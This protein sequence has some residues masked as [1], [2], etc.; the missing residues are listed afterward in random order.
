[1]DRPPAGV[2]GVLWYLARIQS[3]FFDATP[4]A[5]LNKTLALS[6][7]GRDERSTTKVH[8]GTFGILPVGTI[9]LW[10]VV[11]SKTDVDFV[12]H[13]GVAMNNPTVSTDDL[14]PSNFFHVP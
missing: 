7:R 3:E 6:A 9:N 8:Q 5:C 13:D 4:L 1:M 10:R 2:W 14:L 12:D 11:A